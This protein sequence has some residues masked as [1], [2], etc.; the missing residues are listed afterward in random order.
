MTRNYAI[1]VVVSLVVLVVIVLRSTSIAE[2]AGAVIA[3]AL[4]LGITYV[5]TR[6][7]KPSKEKDVIIKKCQLSGWH[8][9]FI[10]YSHLPDLDP[11]TKWRIHQQD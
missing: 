3:W 6:W 7:T 4:A 5:V 8:F 9:N 11:P 2:A 1:A 10:S